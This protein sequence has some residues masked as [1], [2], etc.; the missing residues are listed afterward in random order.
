M[1]PLDWTKAQ[2]DAAGR[3]MLTLIGTAVPILIAFKIVTPDQ[4]STWTVWATNV[5]GAVAGLALAL[6]PIYAALR[7]AQTAAPDNQAKQA[8]KNLAANVPISEGR[9]DDL[10][11]AVANQPDVINVTMVSAAE[12]ER[13]PSPKVT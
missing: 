11:A 5:F 7:A 4:A 12:A 13:I 6:A 9:R 2:W 3:H 1:N 8:A 10:I